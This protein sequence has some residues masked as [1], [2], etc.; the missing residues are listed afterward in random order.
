MNAMS[1]EHLI[2]AHCTGPVI[3]GRC[4]ACRAAKAEVHRSPSGYGP[5]ILIAT[6][7]LLILLIALAA[8]GSL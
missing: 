5:H 8:H 1:C 4:P 6:V 3:E 7:L 2:C